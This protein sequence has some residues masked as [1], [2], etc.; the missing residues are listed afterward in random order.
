MNPAP[1]PSTAGTPCSPQP[2]SGQRSNWFA[3]RGILN[4]GQLVVGR[5]IN[6]VNHGRTHSR[7]RYKRKDQPKGRESQDRE[8]RE[9]HRQELLESLRF[10]QMDAR[11]VNVKK[12]HKQTCRWFLKDPEYLQW[13]NNNETPNR[14]GMLWI[15]GKPGAGKSTLMKFLLGNTQWAQQTSILHF[16]FN[17]RGNELERTTTGLY[18]SLLVQLL[19]EHQNLQSV[20]DRLPRGLHRWASAKPPVVCFIDALD[21][22]HEQEVRD[23][24]AY[25]SELCDDS[26]RLQICLASRHYPHITIGKGRSITLENKREHSQDIANYVSNTLRIGTGKMVDEIQSDLQ[27]KASGVFMWV[28]L[29]VNI[30]NKEWDAGR[31][32]GLRAR[33]HEMPGDLHTLFRDMLTRDTDN[34]PGLLLCMQWLLFAMRPLSPKQLYFAMISGLE[35]ENLANCHTEEIIDSDIARFVLDVSKGLAEPTN[36]KHPTIQ[37]IHESVRDFLLKDNG[38]QS[39]WPGAESSIEGQSHEVL[40]QACLAYLTS[41]PVARLDFPILL[42]RDYSTDEMNNTRKIQIAVRRRVPFLD[43]VNEYILLHAEVAQADGYSQSKFLDLFPLAKWAYHHN[44]LQVT[45]FDHCTPKVTLR[46]VLAKSNLSSL[47]RAQ[48]ITRSCLDVENE[49]YGTSLFAALATNSMN[50]VHA[51][52]EGEQLW[53][54]VNPSLGNNLME[55]FDHRDW[56]GDFT[57]KFFYSS[58]KGVVSYLVQLGGVKLLEVLCTAENFDIR[59]EDKLAWFPLFYAIKR[60]DVG[61]ATILIDR[62]ADV[63]A[64]GRD[65]WT[66]L[67]R[68]LVGGY[69]D[70]ARLLIERGADVNTRGEFDRASITRAS[71]KGYLD[72]VRL[73]V[74][75]GA[76][77]NITEKDGSTP[78]SEASQRGYIDVAQFLVERGADVNAGKGG[79]RPL[80]EAS[81]EGHVYVAQLL[82]E[83]GAD[84]NT[85]IAGWTPLTWASYNGLLEVVEMLVERGADVNAVN[86][87]NTAPLAYAVAK[88]HIG[89]AMLLIKRGAYSGTDV[90]NMI[91]DS[92]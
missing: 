31:K 7:V 18:R 35:P 80:F 8:R 91:L 87:F 51:L 38:L 3:G 52:I 77:V 30:L 5:D 45:Q 69:V 83:R 9:V 28:A 85:G 59:S 10:P 43:Y 54:K 46:Y 79:S 24:I 58:Y 70:I 78:L 15:R 12:A 72:V 56:R 23:M 20:L 86:G 63:N 50:A 6:I 89:V 11:H 4:D 49:R 90:L 16:F 61:V 42:P 82:I 55:T 32:H 17:A 88:S 68:A 27:E 37:F 76:D 21:E 33:L 13:L 66:A 29:V 22:C 19:D 48:P 65:G 60:Y 75:R 47:M 81:W 53:G 62:G 1:I 84:V 2:S 25:L 92:F 36:S 41:E 74:D 73:L 14:G 44:L 64:V 34:T 57:P 67:D 26:N 71:A 40:K 39:I